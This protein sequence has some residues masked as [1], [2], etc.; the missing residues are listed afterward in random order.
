MNGRLRPGF[1]LALVALLSLL[2][3][4]CV[5]A[6]YTGRQQIML[7]DPAQEA[8]LG[9][10]AALQVTRQSKISKNPQ[11]NQEVDQVGRRIAQ[12][13]D[14]PDFDWEFYVVDDAKTV[15]AFCLPGGKVFVYT[16]M[17]RFTETDDQLATVMAHEVAHAIARH[18]AERM[19]TAM[20]AQA[21]QAVAAAALNIQSPGALRAF[22][23]A[24]GLATNVGVILPFSRTQEYEAD[25]IGLIIMAKAGYNPEAAIGFWEKM[26]SSGDQSS[27]PAFLSTHPADDERLAQ[28]REFMPE[29]MQYYSGKRSQ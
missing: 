27:M 11:Y 23:V 28:I 8:A 21:G 16:G 14:R 10:R 22:D 19:S 15:N 3:P 12:V 2:L 13:A 9:E 29:A 5:T 1:S 17:L 18:G 7:I 4:S 25:R 20:V 24:Y 6:P 26:R